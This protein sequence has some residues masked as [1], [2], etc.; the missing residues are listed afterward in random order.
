MCIR[1]S[2]SA[3]REK[4]IKAITGLYSS[5]ASEEDI[6]VYAR[7]SVYDDPWSYCDT[8]Y[9]VRVVISML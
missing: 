9:K 7:D 8:R 1:D 2:V 5:S 6:M 4:V 3:A